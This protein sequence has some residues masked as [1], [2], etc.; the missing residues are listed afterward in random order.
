MSGF[1]GYS[2][3]VAEGESLLAHM[4]GAITQRGPGVQTRFIS[5]SAGLSCVTGQDDHPGLM[6]FEA[7][8]MTIALHGRIFNADELRDN[9]RARGQRFATTNDAE[10]VLQLYAHMGEACLPLLNG[11]FSFALW[12]EPRRRM[13]FARDRIGARPLF[14]TTRGGVLYFASQ[15]KALLQVPGVEARLDPFA[16]DQIFTLW[17]PI[18]PRTSFVDIHELEPAS[19]MI[20]EPGKTTIRPYWQFSFPPIDHPQPVRSEAE[21]VEELHALLTDAV[22]L[23]MRGDT[24]IGAYLSGGL[25]SSLVSALVADKTAGKLKTFSVNFDSAEHDESA[26]Q[27]LMVEALNSEHRSLLCGK[28]DIARVFPEVIRCTEQPIIRTA[29][30]PL[31]SLA[32]FV[33]ETGMKVVLTGEGADEIFAGYDL[34]KEARLRRFCARQPTS[35]IRPH[36]FFKLYPY[37][38]NLQQQSVE[39][40]SAFFHVG[41]GQLD[42]PLF[43]HRPRFKTTS[44]AKLFYSGQLRAQLKGYDATDDLAGRLPEE[45]GA[46]HPLH[47]AQYLETRFLLPGYILPCQGERMTTAQGIDA[48]FPFLDPRIIEFA[49]RLPPEMKLKGLSEKHIIRKMAQDLVPPAILDRPK[50]PYRAPD[51]QAFTGSG[52]LD[53]VKE[54]LGEK[55]IAASGLFNASAVAK[56]QQK[57]QAGATTGFRDNAAFVGIL[58]TQLWHQAFAG[59]DQGRARPDD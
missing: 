40:L 14:Y 21:A 15:V 58:S 28:G 1:T 44:G 41:E 8:Q 34:F 9:L 29:P 7:G 12:D 37:L 54:A 3:S 59:Q 48:R 47:Q 53:Y 10:L 49:S 30:A 38:P 57:C 13:V 46:W 22:R 17:A 51:S 18:A 39:F 5:G 45:F 42:D 16:L 35:R 19:V 2:G 52:N 55:S 33:Y 20:A 36:L 4:T 27:R 26:Y 56:L 43:S 24:E 23:R 32:G 25:D 6:T 11:D 31:H 50:Q